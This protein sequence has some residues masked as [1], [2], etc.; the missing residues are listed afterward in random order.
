MKSHT[1]GSMPKWYVVK[2]YRNT[3]KEI[4]W[5]M[6]TVYAN[7]NNSEVISGVSFCPFCGENL[8]V[9]N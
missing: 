8:D 1:C 5:L 6:K 2:Q 3:K 9:E 7:D 4:A